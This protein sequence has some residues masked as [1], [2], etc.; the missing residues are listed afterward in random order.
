MFRLQN[1]RRAREQD[2]INIQTLE[3]KLCDE[4]QRRINAEQSLD[5]ERKA[6][7]KQREHETRM[8]TRAQERSD[9]EKQRFVFMEYSHTNKRISAVA[10]V[11]ICVNVDA[12][13]PILK[14]DNLRVN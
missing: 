4:Q 14:C 9:A 1:E 13:A 10:N 7:Q 3:K 8:A 6:Q 11:V 2:K 5:K 12:S